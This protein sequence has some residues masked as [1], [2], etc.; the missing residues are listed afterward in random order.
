MYGSRGIRRILEIIPLTL[1]VAG[2]VLGYRFT[3]LLI[4]LYTT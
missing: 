2:I 3:L 4:T 1:A